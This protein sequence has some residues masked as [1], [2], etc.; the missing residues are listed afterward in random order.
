MAALSMLPAGA[1]T[2]EYGAEWR[3]MRA[4]N[5]RL[6]WNMNEAQLHLE[7]TGLVRNL[8]KVEDHYWVTYDDKYCAG[9]ARMKTEEGKKRRETT[10]A[11]HSPPGKAQLVERNLDNN[12]VVSTREVDIP[13]CVHDVVAGLGQLR[14]LRLN[15]GQT[16]HLPVSDG[17]KS[18]SARIEVQEKEK[19]KTSAGEFNTIRHEVF[20]YNGVLYRRKARLF[21]WLSDD[22]KRTPVQI[23]VKF[24]F[25]LGTVTLQL[26]KENP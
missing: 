18:V 20:L 8:Y 12:E 26:E 13:A 7:T 23:R 21:V 25:Y 11:Y 22:D 10:V 6:S 24:P 16:V 17:K 4:G 15:P 5:V 2:F 14:R 3:L 19:I 1:E 9:S